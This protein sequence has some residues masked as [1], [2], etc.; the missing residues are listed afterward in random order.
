MSKYFTSYEIKSLIDIRERICSGHGLS[1]VM[2]ACEN[3]GNF[4][5][6][7]P[8]LYAA[9]LSATHGRNPDALSIH[10]TKKLKNYFTDEFFRYLKENKTVEPK[11]VVF[12]SSLP[13]DAWVKTNLFKIELENTLNTASSFFRTTPQLNDFMNVLDIGPACRH[14]CGNG[15]RIRSYYCCYLRWFCR[16]GHCPKAPSD[17]NRISR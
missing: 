6:N 10:S 16:R 7:F 4:K 3:A 14:S 11:V 9:V 17:R 12:K 8:I 1:S 15:V 2:E 5:D 13:Y